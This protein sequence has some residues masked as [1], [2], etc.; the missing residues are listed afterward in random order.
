VSLHHAAQVVTTFHWNRLS[1][2]VGRK[3]VL[4]FC[5]AGTIV[6]IIMFGLSRSFWILALRYF[7]L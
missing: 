4:L 5:L 7:L 3:P 6:S 2:H 1:D